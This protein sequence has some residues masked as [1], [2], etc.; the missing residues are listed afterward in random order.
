[1]KT[2][3]VDSRYISIQ[4]FIKTI[5]LLGLFFILCGSVFSLT[6]K[7]IALRSNIKNQKEQEQKLLDKKTKL[8]SKTALLATPL[9]TEIALRDK[10]RILKPNEGMVIITAPIE[11]QP[12]ASKS[13]IVRFWDMIVGIFN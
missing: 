7:Y 10:Y 4:S 5:V 6:K 13:R 3:N 2:G 12:E 11:A 9:G 1:M 8:Q